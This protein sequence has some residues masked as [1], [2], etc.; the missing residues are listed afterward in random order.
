MAKLMIVSRFSTTK[1]SEKA[2]S[3]CGGSAAMAFKARSRLRAIGRREKGK[4]NAEL[5]CLSPEILPLA[6]LA[7]VQ[8]IG[9]DRN[10]VH[11]G[12]K[13]MQEL[14]ALAVEFRLHQSD[15]GRVEERVRQVRCDARRYRIGTEFVD[16]RH[17]PVTLHHDRC[18]RSMCHDELDTPPLEFCDKRRDILER[19]ISVQT[20]EVQCPRLMV[21]LRGEPIAQCGDKCSRT[22]L[23]AAADEPHAH[24][25]RGFRCRKAQCN[26]STAE[27]R[28]QITSLHMRMALV[29]HSVDRGLRWRWPI[30]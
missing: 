20:F 15:P 5:L 3:A 4:V 2:I 19:V 10:P 25:L 29:V 6:R 16:N 23:V 21:A 30:L 17:R 1:P 7:G 26:H 24:R 9:D 14:E 13:L 18:R 27:H 11:F 22:F 8:R 28:G 12:R